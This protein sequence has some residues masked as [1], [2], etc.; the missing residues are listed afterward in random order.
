VLC[1]IGSLYIRLVHA[2]GR[3][4]VVRGHIPGRFWTEGR[5]FVLAFW[6]GRLLMMPYSWDRAVAIRML[7]SGHRDGQIIARTVSHF[8]IETIQ[9]STKKGGASALRAMV[10]AL[11]SGACVGITPDG[12]RGP[13]MRASDGVVTVA[14]M[15]GVPVIPATYSAARRKVLGTWDGFVVAWPFGRGVIVWGEPVSVPRDADTEAQEAARLEIEDRL[16]AITAEADRLCGR[17]PVEPEPAHAEPA[18]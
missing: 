15:S 13:R 1:W 16:N 2:T 14:R 6:H 12:P 7:I 8:G 9:G 3:W 18:S 5:P 10:G 4:G 11:K 17:T